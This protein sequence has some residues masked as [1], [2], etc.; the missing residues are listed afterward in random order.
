MSEYFIGLMSGTSVDGIDAVLVDAATNPP[1]LLAQH[2]H[3]LPAK[4][5]TGLLAFN[6][7]GADELH[8]MAL[9]D[10]Q[11]A[12]HCAEA[13]A[14]LLQD[15]GL[16]ASAIRAI[17]SHGQT[18]RH[19]PQA[20]DPYTVQITNPSL[21]AELTGITVVADFRR[22]DMAAGG[23][24]APLAPAFHA[25]FLSDTTR[26]RAVVNIGGIANLT[27][28]IP[29]QAV[30]GFDTGPGN[31]LLDAWAE[32]HLEAPMDRDG[33]WASGG[34]SI[35]QLLDA[36][37]NDAYFSRPVP[38]STGRDY[39]N[40]AWLEPHLQPR[41]AAQDVHATLIRLTAT[42]IA[43]ALTHHAADSIE[44][45][46][47]GGGVHNPVL[48]AALQS[49]LPTLTVA[50]TACQGVDPDYMEAIGFAWL[51]QQTLAGKPGNL[52]SVTGACEPRI[53]GGIYPGMTG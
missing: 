19:A 14:I 29:G 43:Q 27:R 2:R 45:L 35:P 46:V 12:R 11:L 4:L 28:L 21:L 26:P 1:R 25:A 20:E 6:Q 5:R 39:F 23:Q 48:M 22:R 30:L 8:R 16:S 53:L 34:Q 52:A 37:L 38:K 51:A 42:S 36:L 44:L 10:N 17:G 31:G 49:Q 33:I 47:C 13:V 9:L 41:M 40:R 3:A 24:G 18:L 7:P 15:S 32:Q 50:S